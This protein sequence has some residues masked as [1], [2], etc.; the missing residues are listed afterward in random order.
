MRTERQVS[1]HSSQ[2]LKNVKDHDSQLFEKV[3]EPKTK[4]LKAIGDIAAR[5]TN[6]RRTNQI[7][8]ETWIA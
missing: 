8:V 4:L 6:E 3:T 1:P 7:I 2:L 5:D